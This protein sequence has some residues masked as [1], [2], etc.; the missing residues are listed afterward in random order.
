MYFIRISGLFA[1]IG[2][3]ICQ[4]M[5]IFTVKNIFNPSESIQKII[6]ARNKYSKRVENVQKD[7]K[8]YYEHNRKVLRTILQIISNRIPFLGGG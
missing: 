8:T 3:G 2:A 7:L 4:N 1:S 6:V 5:L